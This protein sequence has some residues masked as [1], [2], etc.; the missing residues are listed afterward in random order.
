[1]I[2]SLREAQAE[3]ED[4]YASE[5]EEVARVATGMTPSDRITFLNGKTAAY[6]TKMMDRWNNLFRELAVKYNDQPGGYDQQFYDEIVRATGDRF[7][8][9]ETNK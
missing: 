7:K 6:T 5:Q 1:M 4:F 2:G 3:L 8:V 9:P